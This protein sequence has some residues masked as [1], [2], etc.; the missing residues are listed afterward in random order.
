VGEERLID[1]RTIACQKQGPGESVDRL[2]TAIEGITA[3]SRIQGM[4]ASRV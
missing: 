4:V 1:D 2:G 3:W